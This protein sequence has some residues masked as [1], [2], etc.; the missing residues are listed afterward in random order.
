[1][2]AVLSIIAI[3]VLLVLLVAGLR[4][5]HA[6]RVVEKERAGARAN[7]GEAQHERSLL[8][9]AEVRAAAEAGTIAPTPEGTHTQGPDPGD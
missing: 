2:S 6:T 8:R 3:A 4:M 1:M 9:R 5:R 7:V